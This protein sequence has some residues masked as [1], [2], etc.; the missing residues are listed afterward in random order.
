M[1]NPFVFGVKRE[2]LERSPE[3]EEPSHA[4][5]AESGEEDALPLGLPGVGFESY[6]TELDEIL[7]STVNPS[8]LWIEIQRYREGLQ[9]FQSR[10]SGNFEA[11]AW[12][13]VRSWPHPLPDARSLHSYLQTSGGGAFQIRF[14]LKTDEKA[15]CIV[16]VEETTMTQAPPN[17]NPWHD[18]ALRQQNDNLMGKVLDK[19]LDSLSSRDGSDP[20]LIDLLKEIREERKVLLEQSKK[21]SDPEI[22]GLRRKIEE[23]EREREREKKGEP[24]LSLVSVLADQNKLLLEKIATPSMPPMPVAPTSPAP[25]NTDYTRFLE[26]QLELQRE[27]MKE[28]RTEL[29]SLSQSKQNPVVQAPPVIAPPSPPID[30]F[31]LLE[32]SLAKAAKFKKLLRKGGLFEDEEA[33][34]PAPPPATTNSMVPAPSPAPPGFLQEFG[35]TLLKELPIREM[36]EGLMA[37]AFSPPATTSEPPA[38]LRP[39]RSK[40]EPSARTTSSPT[41]PKP[42]AGA[43]SAPKAKASPPAPVKKAMPPKPNP[44]LPTNVPAPTSPASVSPEV[45]SATSP[46]PTSAV[47]VDPQSWLAVVESMVS[48]GQ[49][50]SELVKLIPA[51]LKAMLLMAPPEAI[52]PQLMERVPQESILRSSRGQRWLRQAL[53]HLTAG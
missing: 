36:A 37:R 38:D 23:L 18:I 3:T 41:P 17:S 24:S 19:A 31:D 25:A 34:A 35:S 30:P 13:A 43:T 2:A 20:A 28:L 27:E 5:D 32:Q 44:S 8:L 21:A 12:L 48:S 16:Q 4:E 22:D 53:G 47:S 7:S 42:A 50:P 15:A 14:H 39:P 26:R 40:P 49:E 45:P 6:Q 46:A 29:R 11:S 51:S 9:A 52:L 1:K 33:P 10:F